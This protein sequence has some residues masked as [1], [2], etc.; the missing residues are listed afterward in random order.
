MNSN[1]D[2]KLTLM[3]DVEPLQ[4][5]LE[6]PILQKERSSIF[7]RERKIKKEKF[8]KTFCT[9]VQRSARPFFEYTMVWSPIESWG[10]K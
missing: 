10:K 3:I 5:N 2:Y 4:V 9:I 1:A 8:G 6:L 7:I